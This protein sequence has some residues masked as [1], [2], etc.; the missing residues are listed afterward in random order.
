MHINSACVA[1]TT[2]LI[3]IL[4]SDDASADGIEAVQGAWAIQGSSC[5][6]VFATENGKISLRKRQ[7]DALPGFIVDGRTLKG[8]AAECKIASFKPR[9]DGMSLL[10]SCESQISFGNLKVTLKIPDPNS[11]I[12]VDDEFPDITTSFHRCN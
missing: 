7:D 11:L 12:R 4:S 1:V 8:G 3:A 9:P 6:D 2:L 10:L 5:S